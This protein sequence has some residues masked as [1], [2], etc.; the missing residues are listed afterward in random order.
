MFFFVCSRSSFAWARNIFQFPTTYFFGRLQGTR[1]LNGKKDEQA[2]AEI[3]IP[4][5]ILCY[6]WKHIAFGI[7]MAF[8]CLFKI[9]SIDS[10]WKA[11]MP[12][13]TPVANCVENFCGI[14]VAGK[15]DENL[16]SSFESYWIFI[17]S[18]CACCCNK[19]VHPK[20][21]LKG[22]FCVIK[23]H[24]KKAQN[25]EMGEDKLKI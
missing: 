1:T 14:S 25:H 18:I 2:T 5:R 19:C 12:T 7:V 8:W 16:S 9:R 13:D 20:L 4:Y 23:M 3:M 11:S 24:N 22:C 21:W 17:N 15:K 6:D 10:K